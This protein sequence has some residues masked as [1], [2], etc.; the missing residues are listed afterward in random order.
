MQLN[1]GINDSIP[2]TGFINTS[3]ADPTSGPVRPFGL[4]P[5]GPSFSTAGT[6]CPTFDVLKRALGSSTS[7]VSF[8]F[9]AFASQ[10]K[11]EA[12]FVFLRNHD[13]PKC[14]SRNSRRLVTGSRSLCPLEQ[15]V[16]DLLRKEPVCT[17]PTVIGTHFPKILGQQNH[18]LSSNTVPPLTVSWFP[19][20]LACRS[21]TFCIF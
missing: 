5:F 15:R 6:A 3:S 9:F 13:W 17:G 19:S 8:S 2:P 10:F 14:W 1:K 20:S 7:L 21:P 18:W 4:F 12:S 11:A 16:S